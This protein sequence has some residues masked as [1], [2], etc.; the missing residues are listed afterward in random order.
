MRI[1][2]TGGRTYN[3]VELIART[4]MTQTTCEDVIIHGGAMGLDHYASQWAKEH[5][6]EVVEYKAEWLRYG[7]SA[8]PRR[9]QRMLDDGKPDC[10]IAFPGGVG[11]ADMVSRAVKAG[12]PVFLAVVW[13]AARVK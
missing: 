3:D 1:I 10:V 12:V 6:R 4:L 9:N 13:E 5:G 7:R 11:T 2:V 8:G